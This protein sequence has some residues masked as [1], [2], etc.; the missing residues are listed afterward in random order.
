METQAQMRERLGEQLGERAAMRLDNY[1]RRYMTLPKGSL[2]ELSIEAWELEAEKSRLQSTLSALEEHSWWSR[3]MYQLT[4]S[5]AQLT[6]EQQVVLMILKDTIERGESFSEV[7]AVWCSLALPF[8]L[9][10]AASCGS[11]SACTSDQQ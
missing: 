2:G 9:H 8:S 4:S 6:Q 5:N 10:T 3:L 7:R 11:S 1:Q